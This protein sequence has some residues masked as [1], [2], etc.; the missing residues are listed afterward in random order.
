VV[1][2]TLQAVAGVNVEL[3]VLGCHFSFRLSATFTSPWI[4]RNF[5]RN[6]P[7]RDPPFSGMGVEI[8]ALAN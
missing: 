6:A 2:A 3:D 7:D 1:H 8:V 4:R 5:F